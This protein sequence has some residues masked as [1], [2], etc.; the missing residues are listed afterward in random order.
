MAHLFVKGQPG[1]GDARR[2][3][4]EQGRGIKGVIFAG[5]DQGGRR[6]FRQAVFEGMLIDL[7]QRTWKLLQPNGYVIYHLTGETVIDPSQ[8]GLCS[9]CFN[10]KTAAWDEAICREMGLALSVLPDVHPSRAII[11]QVSAAAAQ[12]TGLP[13]GTPVVCGGGDFACAC[14]G[15]GVTGPG[16]AA[17]MLGT[18]GNL[19]V[20]AAV[21][22]DSRLLHTLHV[23]GGPLSFGGVMAGG[24][25]NWFNHLLG[26]YDP[27]IYT[28]LDGEAS[29]LPPGAEGLVYLPY[30]MGERTP[31]WDP[32]ARGA[33]IGL[34]SRHSRAHLYRAILEGVAFAF[35]QIAEILRASG[36]SFEAVAALDGGARSALWR[37]ID[38]L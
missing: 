11:G 13:Q 12:A 20:P 22:P 30:L 17:M 32:E 28:I 5:Y 14:L 38:L 2:S 21:A 7:F 10:L 23:T 29:L 26:T 9:P 25:L 6:N 37:Q 27:H 3:L 4:T 19:L 31:I 8:A 15:A 34:S 1:I 33:F 18:A 36:A 24:N 35:R 16:R